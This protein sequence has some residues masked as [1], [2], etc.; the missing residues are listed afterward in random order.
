MRIPFAKWIDSRPLSF[1]LLV[2]AVLVA[3]IQLPSLQREVIDWDE[4]TFVLVAA[5]ILRGHLPYEQLYDIKPPLLF[6]L[7]AGALRLFGESI[8]TVRIFGDLCI[9]ATAAFT[10]LIARRTAGPAIAGLATA[11]TIAMTGASYAL[12]TSSELPA[13]AF[14]MA[15]AWAIL[16][17]PASAAAALAAGVLMSL[18]VLVR[19]NLAITAAAALLYFLVNCLLERSPGRRHALAGYALGLAL[20]VALLF[21]VYYATGQLDLL[22]LGAIKVPLSYSGNQLGL[23]DALISHK[24]AWLG[25]VRS[26]P[27]L[28]VPATLALLIAALSLGRRA[29]R[30][31]GDALAACCNRQ[32]AAVLARSD[33]FLLLLLSASTFLSILKSGAAFPH[34]WLQLYPFAAL[35]LA[36]GLAFATSRILRRGLLLLCLALVVASLWH[37]DRFA[38]FTASLAEVE[39]G[40]VGKRAAAEIGRDMRPG[41]EVWALR[42]HV[43]LFHLGLPPVSPL[44]HPSAITR[45]SVFR[46]LVEAGY[47]REDEFERIVAR[48]PRYVAVRA[49]AAE[50]GYLSQEQNALLRNLLAVD[51]RKWRSTGNIDVYKRLGL[52]E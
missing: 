16:A 51:Y 24:G 40:Y 5:D 18:A 23:L 25:F 26:T 38:E 4:I 35:L 28:F 6:F 22:V 27:G 31:G 9:L 52:E 15:S 14:V 1:W 45:A 49:D 29:L 11:A 12:H 19:T 7:I 36:Y 10:F 32:R 20:P 37:L 43:I 2:F 8:A 17:F 13:M 50:V 48:K 46:P 34:Y 44:A 30:C 39:A 3:V 33:G 47:V 41:D 21:L 42:D